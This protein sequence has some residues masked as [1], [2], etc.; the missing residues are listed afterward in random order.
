VG[1]FDEV[2]I[3]R[4]NGMQSI[5]TGST[6]KIIWGGPPGVESYRLKVSFDGGTTWKLLADQYAD[7]TFNW[8]IPLTPNNKTRCLISVEGFDANRA[9]VGKDVSDNMF[10]V[11]VVRLT[12]PNGGETWYSGSSYPIQWVTQATKGSVRKVQLLYTRDGGT[13]WI[14]ITPLTDNP[15]TYD[16]PIPTVPADKT[17][18]KVKVVLKDSAGNILGNDISDNTFTILPAPPLL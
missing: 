17:K 8:R 9:L 1:V 13:T 16:W 3:V 12:S 2:T 18:C 14:P 6:Y 15:E 4:P 11:E 5:A 10:T 7:R